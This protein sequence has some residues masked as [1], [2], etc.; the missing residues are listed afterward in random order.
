[1]SDAAPQTIYLKD[2]QPFGYL[3][4]HVSLTFKLHPTAT[5]VTSEIKFSPNPDANDKTFFL[6]GE[7]L[8]LKWAKI[9]GN[10]ISPEISQTGLTCTIPDA[11]F[12][13]EAAFLPMSAARPTRSIK[14]SV[15]SSKLRT[16][17]IIPR[18]I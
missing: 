12:T 2:Y 15:V 18:R 1:M 7:N 17:S 14:P 5:R 6:H 4:E 3:V 16:L 9:D 10:P 11:P 8:D 13:F